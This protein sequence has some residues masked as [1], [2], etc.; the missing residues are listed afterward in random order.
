MLNKIMSLFRKR[1]RVFVLTSRIYESAGGRTK[2]TI[3]RMMFLQK[4][5]EATLIEMSETKYPGK[6]LGGIFTKYNTRFNVVNPWHVGGRSKN[7][8]NYL[9][10]LIEQVGAG[11][12]DNALQGA[13]ETFTLSTLSGGRI[14]S[15]LDDNKIARLR[16]FHSN[17]TV[18][19]FTLD[20][21]QNIFIKEL[22][23]GERLLH[24]Y[25]VNEEGDV[26]AGFEVDTNDKR[27]YLYR[28]KSDQIVYSEDI[29]GHL[30]IFL[31]DTLRDGDVVIS[32]VRYYD[33]ALSRV[34][35]RIRKIH[36]WHEIITDPKGER[37]NGRYRKMVDADTLMPVTDKIVVFTE[38]TRDEYVSKFPHLEDNMVVIPYGT[39]IKP[40]IDSV[41]RDKNTILSL[42]RLEEGKNVAAQIRAFALFHKKYSRSRLNIV[43]DGTAKESLQTLVKKLKL[44]DAVTFVGFSH[45]VDAEFQKSS[46]MIFSSDTESFGLTIL[47]SMSNGT[48][49]ASYD[50]HFGARSLIREGE[51]GVIAKRNTPQA[52]ADAMISLRKAKLTPSVVRDS[53]KGVFSKK[54][55]EKRWRSLISESSSLECDDKFAGI[56]KEHAGFFSQI[57]HLAWLD[58]QKTYRGALLGWL[59]V[60]VRPLIMLGFYWFIIVIG[61]RSDV[62]AGESYD[63]LSWLA[64][65]LCVWFF[66]S[67][68]IEGGLGAFRRYKFL[69]TKTKF[70]VATIPSIVLTS[71]FIVHAILLGLVLVYLCLSGYFAIEWIQLPIYIALTLVF[72]WLWSFLAAPLGAMSK[73]F[74]QLVK[75]LLRIVVW[76]SGII[77]SIHHI[78]VPWLREVME[79]NPIFFLA[80]GYRKVLIYHDWFFE[81]WRSLLI[82]LAQLVILGILAVVIYKRTRKEVVDIL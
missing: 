52:L 30:A 41:K 69:I 1:P 20:D 24:R 82:F 58:L 2:A 5:Y 29:I 59:W 74:T 22:Y 70:P 77:W 16:Q 19:L 50:V 45:N 25:Y 49:V 53:I 32:D 27:R 28:T 21:N 54:A 64:V 31:N 76:I 81:D 23:K 42:G 80:D 46:M 37:I 68:M 14:R 57:W 36:V 44:E 13:Q 61:L 12:D 72:V 51:N 78:P 40:D 38:D 34:N 71:N 17:G 65:G 79:L 18:T 15:Y 33:E 10:L 35:H 7:E 48:P 66:I 6:E 43:G 4:Y 67:D 60:I 9:K 62:V 63:Y 47:E 56:P 75:S 8:K 26:Y 39:N 73:D 11:I 55:F 3:E